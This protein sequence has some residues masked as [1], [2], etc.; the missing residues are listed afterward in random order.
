M[1]GGLDAAGD[2][3]ETS[4]TLVFMVMVPYPCWLV[5]ECARNRPGAMSTSASGDGDCNQHASLRQTHLRA[6]KAGQQVEPAH[7]GAMIY[8]C[9]RW[10]KRWIRLAVLSCRYSGTSRLQE[11]DTVTLLESCFH[12][13]A[14]TETRVGV[15]NKGEVW[16]FWRCFRLCM[17]S[18]DAGCAAKC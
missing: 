16:A 18:Q 1:R 17:I 3:P 8:R 14:T 9:K 10:G 6:P 12:P 13:M 15:F 2:L 4:D 7:P 5:I 11:S